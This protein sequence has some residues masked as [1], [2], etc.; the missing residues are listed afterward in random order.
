TPHVD[1]SRNFS[2]RR[3]SDDRA[4]RDRLVCRALLRC[5]LLV[6]ANCMSPEPESARPLSSR[7]DDVMGARQCHDKSE[8]C[9]KKR[10]LCYTKLCREIAWPVL[11]NAVETFCGRARRVVVMANEMTRT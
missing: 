1:L 11:R 9:R 4:D 5:A 7:H 6:H 10:S 3:F 2:R 8:M